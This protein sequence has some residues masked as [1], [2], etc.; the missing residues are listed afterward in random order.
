[1][2]A[3]MDASSCGYSMSGAEFGCWGMAEVF[4]ELWAWAGAYQEAEAGRSVTVL[5]EA[6]EEKTSEQGEQSP[7]TRRDRFICTLTPTESC[8]TKP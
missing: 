7:S 3:Y 1:M 2:W 6:T 8:R 4:I 5:T